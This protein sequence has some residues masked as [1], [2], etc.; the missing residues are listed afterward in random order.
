MASVATEKRNGKAYR[1]V[2]FYDKDNRR[3]SIRLGE[4]N[5]K[6]AESIARRVEDLNSCL[7][8]GTSPGK[9][10]SH[11]IAELGDDLREKLR[12]IGFEKFVPEQVRGTLHE[13]LTEYVEGREDYGE[14]TRLVGRNT[15][16]KLTEFFGV[17]RDLRDITP[18]QAAEWR[19]WLIDVKKLSQASVAKHVKGARHF[20]SVA[21]ERNLCPSNPFIKVKV[22]SM[23][24]DA[25][26]E[27]LPTEEVEKVIGVCPDAEWR[28][29][30][31]LSRFAGLRCPSETLRLKW[32]NV[33]W[34]RDRITV[35]SKKTARQGKPHRVIPIFEKLRP[36]LEEAFEAAEPGAEYII[37][38]YRGSQTN[39]RT[40]LHRY[41]EK[42]GMEPWERAFHQ[43]R[44]SCETDLEQHFGIHTA[45]TWLGNSPKVAAEHY[46]SVHP[47]A[48]DAASGATGG[49]EVVQESVPKL[50]VEACS[51][52]Q[53]VEDDRPQ[54]L[55]RQCVLRNSATRNENRRS[56][57]DR[58]KVGPAGFEPATNRL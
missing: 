1:R 41:I 43:M 50:A 40:Q 13:F 26:K 4:M 33:D 22:G 25:R 28:L 14:G 45:A 29:I 37:G 46:L 20:F 58:L 39:L 54:P 55:D 16:N 5:L 2:W 11:W 38:R 34:E 32:A 12:G 53:V 56:I 3:R 47:D 15:R 30:I 27:Y 36:Y 49:A 31:A 51:E 52:P 21:K 9:D 24:N 8:A 44:A 10:L 18:D 17:N 19:Q 57:A 48:F 7:I 35:R 42:A 23:V 6:A